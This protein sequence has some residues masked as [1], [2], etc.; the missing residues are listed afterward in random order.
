MKTK[1][2]QVDELQAHLD[3]LNKDIPGAAEAGQTGVQTEVA[4][5]TNDLSKL[6]LELKFLSQHLEDLGKPASQEPVPQQPASPPVQNPEQ[7]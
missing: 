4:A 7:P 2:A 1:E 3:Q 5:V 6:Q